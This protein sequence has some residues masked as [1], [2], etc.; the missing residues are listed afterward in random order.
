MSVRLCDPHDGEEEKNMIDDSLTILLSMEREECQ[1]PLFPRESHDDPKCRRVGWRGWYQDYPH[2]DRG[3]NGLVIRNLSR[4]WRH[5]AIG[6]GILAA[7]A[8]VTG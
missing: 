3:A 4:H 8:E 1:V 2:F 6:E 7:W 5:A